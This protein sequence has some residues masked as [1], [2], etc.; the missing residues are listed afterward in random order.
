MKKV[1]LFLLVIGFAFTSEAQLYKVLSTAEVLETSET[2]S[3][4]FFLSAKET[5]T[6]AVQIAVDS[7][8]GTPGA[9]ATAQSSTVRA[10]VKQWNKR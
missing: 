4:T 3:Q 2:Y 5:P 10:T 8:S 7:V 6:I 9:T 1:L